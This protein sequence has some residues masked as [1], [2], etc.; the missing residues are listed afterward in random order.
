M[1]EV[2]LSRRRFRAR[3][4]TPQTFSQDVRTENGSNQ[5]SNLA[6]TVLFVP[7]S[8]VKEKLLLPLRLRLPDATVC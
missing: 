5:G 1:S 4:G 6:V 2:P 7:S 8:L 3:R